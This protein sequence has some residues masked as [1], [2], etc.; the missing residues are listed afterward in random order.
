M[1]QFCSDL[2]NDS[3]KIE[4]FEKCFHYNG[5]HKNHYRYDFHNYDYRIY[6]DNIDSYIKKIQNNNKPIKE[7]GCFFYKH[8]KTNFD[9]NTLNDIN[10]LNAISFSSLIYIDFSDY[11]N[12][13]INENILPQSL[14]YLKFGNSFN[15][16]IGKKVLPPSLMELEFGTYYNHEFDIDVLPKTLIYLKLGYC[17]NKEFKK[18]VLPKSLKKLF[19]FSYHLE[20]KK[21]IFL[22]MKIHVIIGTMCKKL[23]IN[24]TKIEMRQIKIIKTP[25]L[26]NYHDIYDNTDF[27]NEVFVALLIINSKIKKHDNYMINPLYDKFNNTLKFGSKSKNKLLKHKNYKTEN[28]RYYWNYV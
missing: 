1:G 18:N 2:P 24:N 4:N 16:K 22:N 26:N 11:F 25:E 20:L 7:I 21:E 23:H 19:L 3:K 6:M 27:H 15:K 9:N 12:E 14:L 8:E 5:Y 28:F 10:K 17:Y 13:I